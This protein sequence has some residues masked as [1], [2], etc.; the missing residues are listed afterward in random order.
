LL[1]SGKKE[2]IIIEDEMDGIFIDEDEPT[3]EE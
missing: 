3:E 2:D 1:N